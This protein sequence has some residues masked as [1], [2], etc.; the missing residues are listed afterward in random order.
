MASEERLAEEILYQARRRTAL[1]E[2]L[3]AAGFEEF[4]VKLTVSGHDF[5]VSL[6]AMR[7]FV[8]S[9]R[10]ESAGTGPLAEAADNGMG[11]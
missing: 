9:R 3:R 2:K 1:L 4:D 8:D 7:R 11:A 5:V 6:D 10:I